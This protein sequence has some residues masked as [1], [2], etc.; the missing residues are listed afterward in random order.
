MSGENYQTA[1]SIMQR[2]SAEVQADVL[3]G[4]RFSVDQRLAAAQVYALLAVVNA[5]VDVANAA[6]GL[7]PRV[8]G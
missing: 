5:L 6:E 4:V 2:L 1:L 7:D 3:G 8:S